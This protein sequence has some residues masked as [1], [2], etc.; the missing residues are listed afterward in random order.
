MV[1]TSIPL[2]SEASGLADELL[3]STRNNVIRPRLTFHT[4]STRRLRSNEQLAFGWLQCEGAGRLGWAAT[5][6]HRVNLG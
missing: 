4:G 6:R 3:R 2:R 5:K 1:A